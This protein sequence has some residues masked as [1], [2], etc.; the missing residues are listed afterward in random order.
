M[1]KSE[2]DKIIDAVMKKHQT[3]KEAADAMGVEEAKKNILLYVKFK[4]VARTSLKENEDIKHLQ[5]Q[6]NLSKAP[7]NDAIKAYDEKIKYLN[8]LVKEVEGE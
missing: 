8:L 5:D 1:G 7:F 3:F 2:K 4:E 6:L